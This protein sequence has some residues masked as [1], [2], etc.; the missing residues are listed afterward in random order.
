MSLTSIQE[1]IVRLNA[2]ER[3]MLIDML[4]ESL[5]EERMKEVETNW[6]TQPDERID[7]LDRGELVE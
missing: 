6:A 7:A 3:A 1:Q 2:T 5:D 4:W